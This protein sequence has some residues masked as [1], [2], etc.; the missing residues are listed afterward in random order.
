M[1][2]L[3]GVLGVFV[4]AAIA[5][6]A[7]AGRSGGAPS[8]PATAT[9]GASPPVVVGAAAS[10]QPSPETQPTHV[11]LVRGFRVPVAGMDIPAAESYLPNSPRDYRAGYH[12]G[13][14]FPVGAGTPV[15]AAK[16]GHIL[17]IDGAF[18]EWSAVE[19]N[20]ALADALALGY[21]PERTLDRIRGRQVWIDHGDGIVTRYAHLQSVGRMQVGEY[22]EAGT[23]IGAV[24]SSGL[25]EGGPHLHFEIRIGDAFYGDGLPGPQLRHALAAAFR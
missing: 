3:L 2:P 20:A 19:R 10:A 8:V 5:V 12:E 22:V 15:L 17:R 11:R 23:V 6:L 16:N 7:T 25:P 21:T 14:D 24:G 18:T 9:P 13:V 4:F 1:R